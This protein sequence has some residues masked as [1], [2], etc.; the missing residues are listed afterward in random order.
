MQM[1]ENIS[2]FLVAFVLRHCSCVDTKA[3]PWIS[4]LY[5]Q[6]AYLNETEKNTFESFRLNILGSWHPLE[7]WK[8]QNVFSKM[9]PFQPLSVSAEPD[10]PPMEVILQPVTSQSIRVTW[11]VNWKP[12]AIYTAIS[13]KDI[14]FLFCSE[15]F[16]GAWITM[17]FTTMNYILSFHP[18]GSQEGVAKWGDP[19]LPDR[20]QRE[21]SG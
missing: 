20:L 8:Q 5:R 2:L 3:C 1:C 16:E 6:K 12:P 11:K 7:T 10:G 9:P 15:V 13:S 19:G 18:P 17:Y 4:S 21:W 14:C